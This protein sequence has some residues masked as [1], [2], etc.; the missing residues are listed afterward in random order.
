[1]QLINDI[2]VRDQIGVCLQYTS[3]LIP[4]LKGSGF[5]LDGVDAFCQVF[6]S[7]NQSKILQE[8]RKQLSSELSIGYFGALTV[9]LMCIIK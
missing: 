4:E 2:H 3:Y 5:G 8:I 6:I 9:G 1:M 7:D